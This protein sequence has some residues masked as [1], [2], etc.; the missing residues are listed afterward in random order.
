MVYDRVLK[1]AAGSASSPLGAFPVSQ[2]EL[3]QNP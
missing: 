2:G 1:V 3:L